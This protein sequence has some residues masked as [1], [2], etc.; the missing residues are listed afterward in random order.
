MSS[1]VQSDGMGYFRPIYAPS[2]ITGAGNVTG[3]KFNVSGNSIINTFGGGTS[4]LPGSGAGITAT[5]GQYL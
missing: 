5:G 4:Y 3:L 2:G 1:F